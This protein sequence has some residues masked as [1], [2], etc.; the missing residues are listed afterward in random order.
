MIAGIF[1]A[2]RDGR[3]PLRLIMALD[4]AG[5]RWVLG[6]PGDQFTTSHSYDLLAIWAPEDTWSALFL[7]A[8]LALALCV[9]IPGRIAR[10]G[11][12]AYACV[13][14][15]AIA[16]SFGAAPSIGT[17]F[18]THVGIALAGS[19]LVWRELSVT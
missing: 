18:L 13:L 19:W 2:W 12:V 1:G 7:A 3:A 16:V 9:F 5:W 4:M 10:A 14:Q 11:L 8:A 15:A 6:R 17:G